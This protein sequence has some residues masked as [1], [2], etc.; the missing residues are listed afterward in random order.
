MRIYTDTNQ[1][2]TSRDNKGQYTGSE[3][4]KGISEDKTIST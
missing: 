4:I 3:T 2:V 1:D